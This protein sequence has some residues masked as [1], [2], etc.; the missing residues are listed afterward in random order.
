MFETNLPLIAKAR[1]KIKGKAFQILIM[2]SF[3]LVVEDKCWWF[4]ARFLAP[5]IL[6]DHKEDEIGPI[7]LRDTNV[8]Y[9]IYVHLLIYPKQDFLRK[10]E[11]I[12]RLLH[13]AKALGP[14]ETFFIK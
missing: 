3:L 9:L 8:S 7:T 12:N 2:S 13:R 11:I 10:K 4:F 1:K 14:R 5:F 6:F